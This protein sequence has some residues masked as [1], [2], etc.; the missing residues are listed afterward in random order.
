MTWPGTRSMNEIK[1]DVEAS[2]KMVYPF[3]EEDGS[4]LFVPENFE[5]FKVCKMGDEEPW[6]ALVL[7]YQDTG[8]DGDLFYAEDYDTLEAM[9]SLMRAEIQSE[10]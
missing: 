4:V 7:E 3:K 6:N 5:A 10:G 8:E 1:K 2:L 9:V